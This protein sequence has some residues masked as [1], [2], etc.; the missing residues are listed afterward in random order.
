MK[1]KQIKAYAVYSPHLQRIALGTIA[2]S[3]SKAIELA[4]CRNKKQ[5][6]ELYRM[7]HKTVPVTVSC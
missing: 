7:G 1:N 2:N 3:R 6:M 5:W 4:G